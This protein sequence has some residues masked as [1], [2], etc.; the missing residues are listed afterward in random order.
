VVD[1]VSVPCVELSDALPELK[2][3]G[4]EAEDGGWI[5]SESFIFG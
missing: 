2:D 4:G 1:P 3:D 5:C